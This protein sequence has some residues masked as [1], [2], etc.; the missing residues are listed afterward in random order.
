MIRF[1]ARGRGWKPGP[2]KITHDFHWKLPAA[3][4]S[5]RSRA[6][7]RDR[8]DSAAFNSDTLLSSDRDRRHVVITELG[9]YAGTVVTS[10][11]PGGPGPGGLDRRAH[12]V[13]DERG[14]GRAVAMA[15]EWLRVAMLACL[16][17]R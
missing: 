13:M 3:S 12:I 9:R 17:G 11:T 10:V 1:R 16:L 8:V 6:W 15:P 14:R 5:V 7:F 4:E 2:G